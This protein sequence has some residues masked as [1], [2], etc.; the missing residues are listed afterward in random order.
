VT[1]APWL[2]Q[3]TFREA[4]LQ[5]IMISGSGLLMTKTTRQTRGVGGGTQAGEEGQE[6]LTLALWL[7]VSCMST[8]T[9][10]VT[11]NEQ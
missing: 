8:D 4:S 9:I 7:Q 1:E 3:S 10:V 5:E 2:T 11:P 6:Q